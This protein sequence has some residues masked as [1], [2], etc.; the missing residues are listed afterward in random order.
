MKNGKVML[1]MSLLA[2]GAYIMIMPGC[3][4][5]KDSTEKAE[6]AVLDVSAESGWNFMA[7][8]QNGS[9][10]MVKATAGVV[11]EVFFK[12]TANQL[13]YSILMNQSGRPEKIVINNNIVL[14]NNFVTT[15]VDAAVVLPDGSIKV[16]REVESGFDITMLNSITIGG[17]D[18]WQNIIKF[19]G[20]ATSMTSGALAKVGAAGTGVMIP[21]DAIGSGAQVLLKAG[22]VGISGDKTKLSMLN[23]SA[24]ESL[25]SVAGCSAVDMNCILSSTTE[26]TSITQASISLISSKEEIVN[27]AEGVLIG[28]YG[29]IQ[30]NLTWSTEG[31]VDLW[32][33]DPNGEKVYWNNPNSAS[34]GYLDVDN[35]SGFG[36]ENIFWEADAAINGTY[37][38]EV[39]YFGGSVETTYAVLI[40]LDG[41]VQ[42]GGQPFTGQLNPDE[43]VVVAE[44]TY[45]TKST[46]VFINQKRKQ[47]GPKPSK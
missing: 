46:P 18:D 21:A 7:V 9:N 14:L 4:K 13:G 25:T 43:T 39:D 32:V 24:I 1:L 33:T 12:P 11:K 40:I 42:N 28:G 38:V 3:K 37:K 41:V 31:D 47:E 6:F 16:L 23:A 26:A 44:F 35:T 22:S 29:D 17:N 34:G 5:D 2:V 15:K 27:T 30:V 10:M 8:A 19:A 45:G 20:H 36:P